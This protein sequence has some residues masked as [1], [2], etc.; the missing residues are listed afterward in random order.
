M[1]RAPEQATCLWDILMKLPLHQNCD[2][3]VRCCSHY[4]LG[5]KYQPQPKPPRR[6]SFA[7]TTIVLAIF[8][9]ERSSSCSSLEPLLSLNLCNVSRHPLQSF[10]LARCVPLVNTAGNDGQQLLVK[11]LKQFVR[12]K[13]G[14]SRTT[15]TLVKRYPSTS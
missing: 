12:E 10:S 5:K 9:F 8:S 3:C 15:Y 4:N 13:V 1:Y 14:S 2:R 7:G 11:Q 6:N